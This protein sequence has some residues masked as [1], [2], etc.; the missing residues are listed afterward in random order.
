[1]GEMTEE[2]H[3]IK[4]AIVEIY[5]PS[6]NNAMEMQNK[7]LSF[8]KEKICPIIEKIVEKYA[9]SGETIRIDKLELDFE[10]FN[11]EHTNENELRKLEQ[12]I[13]EKLIKLISEEG[14]NNFSGEI[15]A[16]VKKIPKEKA[17]EELFLHLLKTGTLPW[18]AKTEDSIS[19]EALAQKIIQQL[20]LIHI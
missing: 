10:N 14:D 18:W 20:S 16:T 19:L 3:I 2:K 13:E 5:V 15:L 6:A 4:K 7:A 17:D 8:F 12:Q 11:P 1:M 9:N